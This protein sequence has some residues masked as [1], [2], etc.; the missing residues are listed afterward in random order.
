MSGNQLKLIACITMLIDHIGF[1]LFPEIRILR[2]IGRISMPL[3][4]YLIAEGC[5]YTRS[6]CRYFAS[7]LS[8]AIF[9]QIA[10]L[11][12]DLSDG[13]LSS[14][15]LN[16]LFTFSLS[17]LICFAY[18]RWTEAV[19]HISKHGMCIDFILFIGT[20]LFAVIC[21]NGLDDLLGISV[22]FDYGPAGILLPVFAIIFSDKER[23]FPMFCIGVLIFNLLLCENIPYIW[24]SLLSLPL[25]AS[26][27]G[28]RGIKRLKLCFYLF[29]PL[30]FAA[31][32][33]IK[34]I[35]F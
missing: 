22:E 12:E 5:R 26:Y 8:L 25:I 3:F 20:I 24:F 4:A 9:C 30:H 32:Y 33:L 35:T 27:T 29:Y 11:I 19:Q 15:Y 16:I 18:I 28:L 13:R 31:L 1:L 6:R 10:Y 14:V 17:I 2:Y 21:C 23:Q 7:V 34:L